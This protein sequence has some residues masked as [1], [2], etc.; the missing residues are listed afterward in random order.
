MGDSLC[1]AHRVRFS[2]SCHLC[3]NEKSLFPGRKVFAVDL[4]G[5][6][7]TST[8]WWA[9][10]ADPEPILGNIEFV[11]KV[12]AV[13]HVVVIHTSRSGNYDR[14]RTEQWL[15]DHGVPYTRIHFDKPLAD[16][17]IDDKAILADWPN[18]AALL[19]HLED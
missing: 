17:Y 5:T 13:G 10:D 8:R 2:V 16:Y 6:L 19:R 4:D 15:A 14:A 9:G 18:L 3:H 11:R 12:F 7:C 1:L